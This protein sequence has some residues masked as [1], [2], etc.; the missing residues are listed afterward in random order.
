ME[1]I[2]LVLEELREAI[3]EL[4]VWISQEQG[5]LDSQ[6]REYLLYRVFR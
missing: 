2:D 6:I 4:I 3:A 1:V 5:F